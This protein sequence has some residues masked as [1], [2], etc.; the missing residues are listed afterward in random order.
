M[1]IRL[2]RPTPQLNIVAVLEYVL[3]ALILLY[4]SMWCQFVSAQ[5]NTFMRLAYPVLILLLLLR[6]RVI[7]IRRLN[8]LVILLALLA[9]YLAG[10]RFNTVRY[11]LYYVGPLM[12]LLL[13]LGVKDNQG[14][15]F[16]LL[17]KL[18]DIVCV[19]TVISLVCFVF[20]TCLDVLPGARVVEYYFANQD[21]SCTTYFHLYYAAQTML[22]FGRDFVR[23][24]GI[25][26]E[27]PG[28]A[29]YLII[30]FAVEMFLRDKPRLWRCAAIC[31]AA[32]TTFSTKAIL[33]VLLVI[34]LK[35]LIS[36][37]KSVVMFRFKVVVLPAVA[38]VLLAAALILLKDKMNTD[39]FFIRL[40]DLFASAK[41]FRTS[42]LFGT[43][44]YNDQSIIDQFNYSRPN[45][46]LSMGLAVL[47]AQGGLF[48][49]ALYLVP[50]VWCIFRFPK[51]QRLRMLAFF[52][53]YLGL[54]FVTNMPFSFLALFLLAFSFE[55]GF[56][57]RR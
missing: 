12:L 44:Y 40:D 31:L 48:M 54:L 29:I 21:R 41:A 2:R 1:T 46:G 15:P 33:L 9:L 36:P 11:L 8:R 55:A 4:N 56:R 14:E 20:G 24:C 30:A 35:F 25:F 37:N 42:P 57:A 32:L 38:V 6:L 52:V 18:D 39:S 53:S 5:S 45:E 10:T 26:A 49:M 22:M 3:M 47:L 50:M 51:E 7:P 34:G 23:N 17:F 27:A 16:D 43:G 13:Y 19:L 28:F